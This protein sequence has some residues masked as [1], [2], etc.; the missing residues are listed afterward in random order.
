MIAARFGMARLYA[1]WALTLISMGLAPLAQAG[2]CYR[3]WSDAAPVVA[4]ERLRSASEVQGDTRD[5]LGAD[6][7]RITLCREDGVFVYRLTVRRT[8]GRI[9]NLKVSAAT[10]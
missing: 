7:V 1:A 5:R 3:E 6:V 9:S 4:R 10:P 8:D 2:E